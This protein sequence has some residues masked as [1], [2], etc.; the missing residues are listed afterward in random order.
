MGSRIARR[1][2]EAGHDVAVWNRDAAKAAPLTGLKATQAR[3]PCEATRAAEVVV[4]MVSDARAL[5]DVTEGPEGVAAG[6]GASTTIVQM[7]TVGPDA[8]ARLASVLP[9]GT[10][11]LDAPVLGSLSEVESGSLKIFVGGPAELMERWSPLLAALGLR[12]TSARSALE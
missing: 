6:A 12:F 1:L 10:G 2:L 8:V 3:T 7:A 5:R 9:A 4:T 11:L